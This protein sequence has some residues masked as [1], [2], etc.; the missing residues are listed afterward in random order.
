MSDAGTMEAG[1]EAVTETAQGGPSADEVYGAIVANAVAVVPMAR[2]PEITGYAADDLAG[3]LAELLA[4]GRVEVFHPDPEATSPDAAMLAL[5]GPEAFRP[6]MKVDID[7]PKMRARLRR[8]NK[9]IM[10][11]ASDLGPD[12]RPA[13]S[14]RRVIRH[15]RDDQAEN[16]PSRGT[17]KLEEIAVD[18]DPFVERMAALPPIER[19][20]VGLVLMV[21]QQLLPADNR[22][23]FP[24][25]L[26]VAYGGQWPPYGTSADGPVPLFDRVEVDALWGPVEGP[27]PAAEC[28]YCG[29][30][31]QRWRWKRLPPYKKQGEKNPDGI[32]KPPG[33]PIDYHCLWC[34]RGS[35]ILKAPPLPK[36]PT[37]KYEPGKLAGGRGRANGNG[38][39]NGKARA[40][41]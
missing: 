21:R 7:L 17:A 39:A 6:G 30:E 24:P 31:R 35:D 14:G 20:A 41:G 26:T 8:K 1:P 40:T 9:E 28:P 4:D 22:N 19:F 15:P 3:P 5:A 33:E 37:R 36:E 16:G 23:A 13:A 34:D 27:V 32:P 25:E 18:R 10:I 11:L 12:D 29:R 2:L 38:H